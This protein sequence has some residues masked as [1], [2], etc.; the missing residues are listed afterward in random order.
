MS[1]IFRE[2]DDALQHDQVEKIWKEHGSTI[3]T[4]I[5]VA[6]LTT[7][8]FSGYKSWDT[9]RDETETSRIITALEQDNPLPA[10]EGVIADSRKGHQSVA[11]FA[12][13]GL[14]LKNNRA[15]EAFDVYQNAID[16]R[17]LMHDFEGLARVMAARLGSYLGAEQKDPTDL[18]KTLAPVLADSK[19]PWIYHAKVEAAVIQAHMQADYT[20]ALQSL[21]FVLEADGAPQDLKQR[22]KAMAGVYALQAAAMTQSDTQETSQEG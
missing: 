21:N 2:V 5:V 19:S 3:V 14:H 20:A 9:W 8:L 7:A 4:A 11:V 15:A 12:T 17:I 1:D 22:A 6:I 18:L 13:A 10:L 16:K